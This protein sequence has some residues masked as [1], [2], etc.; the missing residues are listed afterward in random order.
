MLT[1]SLSVERFTLKAALLWFLSETGE[2]SPV[3]FVFSVSESSFLKLQPVQHRSKRQVRITFIF[4]CQLR[5]RKKIPTVKTFNWPSLDK[6]WMSWNWI[7]SI[8]RASRFCF[9]N[10]LRSDTVSLGMIFFGWRLLPSPCSYVIP[11]HSATERRSRLLFMRQWSQVGHNRKGKFS[12]E[13]LDKWAESLNSL[14][15]SQSEYYRVYK[16]YNMFR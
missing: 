15:A 14:L 10:R 4:R 7:C 13:E 1:G 11:V 8:P 9:E 3:N 5:H 16:S 6:Y 2:R 12:R